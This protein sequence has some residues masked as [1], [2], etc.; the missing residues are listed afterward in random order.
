MCILVITMKMEITYRGVGVKTMYRTGE[1]ALFGGLIGVFLGWMFNRPLEG[2]LAGALV[3]ATISGISG[4]T[5]EK[6]EMRAESRRGEMRLR[7][8]TEN[9]LI[10]ME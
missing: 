4:Y 7:I 5:E 2:A 10:K 3:G 1:G 6:R 8:F 9:P